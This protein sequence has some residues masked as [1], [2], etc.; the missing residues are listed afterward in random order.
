MSTRIQTMILV[1]AV[2]AG[3]QQNAAP[4]TSAT[5]DKAATTTLGPVSEEPSVALVAREEGENVVVDVTFRANA[6]R[7]G[8][9]VA[10]LW[11]RYDAG[12]AFDQAEAGAAA[13]S[14]GKQLIAQTPE[15]GMVR[16]A[17]FATGNLTRIGSGVLAR[18]TFHRTAPGAQSVVLVDKRPVFAPADTDLGVLLGPAAVVGGGR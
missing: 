3:C 7:E 4:P 1:T 11:L 15:T 2:V 16:L 10:E 17:L 6:K 14:A 8:P 18:V 9:R 12:L 13:T 5:P